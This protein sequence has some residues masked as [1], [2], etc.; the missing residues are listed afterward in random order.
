MVYG[1]GRLGGKESRSAKMKEI[2]LTQGKVALVDDRDYKLVSKFKWSHATQGYAV[3]INKHLPRLAMH[4]LILNARHGDISDHIDGNRL[5]NQRAN[6]RKVTAKENRANRTTPFYASP[7]IQYDGRG[8]ECTACP[9]LIV[10]RKKNGGV[11]EFW[12]SP[13]SRSPKYNLTAPPLP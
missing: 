7:D 2:P 8:E 9:V 4:R 5:N 10:L 1:Y 12:R 11:V 13:K 3:S 6:L